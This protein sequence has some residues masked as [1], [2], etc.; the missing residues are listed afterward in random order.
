MKNQIIENMNNPKELERMYR[1]DSE[2][3]IEDFNDAWKSHPESEVLAVW[4]QRLNYQNTA[5]YNR[6]LTMTREFRLKIGRASC[7]ERV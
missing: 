2:T 3:F 7:R 1:I 5:G 4:N 6:T